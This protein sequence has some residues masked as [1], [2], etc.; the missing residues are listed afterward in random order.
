M[1]SPELSVAAP[2][3]AALSLAVVGA[4]QLTAWKARLL[5]CCRASRVCCAV[6]PTAREAW[7][8]G[9]HLGVTCVKCCAGLTALLLVHGVMD[10]RAMALVTGLIALERLAP[11]GHLF[12]RGIGALLVIAGIWRLP[13]V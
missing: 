8:H 9:W 7:R 13:G 5:S 2:A 3:F 1:R 11:A 6:P 12:A 10:L 4:L